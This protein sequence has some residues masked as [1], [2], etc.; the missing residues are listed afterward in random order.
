M[1]SIKQVLGDTQGEEVVRLLRAVE[2]GDHDSIDGGRALAQFER[3]TR[4]LGLV[5][6]AE[7]V[8]EAL[9]YL[10]RP[11]R[12]ALGELLQ[13]RARYTDLTAPGLMRQGVQDPGEIALALQALHREDPALVAQLLG[14]E[15]RDLP[16]MKLTLAALAAVAATRGVRPPQP[17]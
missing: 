17:G 10:S 8:R 11:Q 13:A 5:E 2:R 6:F 3:L 7:V 16:V 1:E 12:L 15:F 4:G 9:G 14:S